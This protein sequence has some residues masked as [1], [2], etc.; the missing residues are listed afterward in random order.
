MHLLPRQ[1]APRLD[2]PLT[3]GGTTDDLAPGD[4]RFTLL[5]FFR[6]LHCPI[7]RGQLRDVER[8]LDDLH[9]AG[10]SRVLAV[11]AETAERSRDLVD[12]WGLDRLD[13]AH[14]LDPKVGQQEWNLFVSEGIKDGEPDVFTEPGVFLVDNATGEVYLQVVASMP[15][16]R[17][18]VDEIVTAARYA[19]EKDYPARGEFD[20]S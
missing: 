9:E 10:V 6:G 5:V 3:R 7:C 12:E 13:V 17:P 19:I 15:F 14:G 1:T 20:A 4:G 8:R 11:S 2:L 18:T 16:S